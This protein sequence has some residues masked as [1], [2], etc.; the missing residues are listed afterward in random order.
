MS[1][2][3]TENVSAITEQLAAHKLPRWHDLPDLDLYM[4]QV[5]ALIDRFL[6]DYP[7]YDEKGLTAS[8]VNNYVKLKA[9]PAPVKKKYNREHIAYLL[10]ICLLKASLPIS[11]IQT[12]IAAGME[13]SSS[14]VFYDHFCDMFEKANEA[15]TSAQAQ[16]SDRTGNVTLD[17][18][19]HAALC[20]QAEKALAEK[21]VRRFSEP[22]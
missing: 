21:L 7:G 3:K 20:A 9:M 22:I 1:T 19:F 4:D 2:S 13:L 11:D 12:L 5:I 14:E 16:Q 15:V 8:M 10:I 6:R 17:S 18:I